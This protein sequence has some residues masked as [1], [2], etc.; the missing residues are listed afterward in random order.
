MHTCV[1]PYSSVKS[2]PAPAPIDHYSAISVQRIIASIKCCTKNMPLALKAKQ[3]GYDRLAIPNASGR[4]WEF[5]QFQVTDMQEC[6]DES[7]I[8]AKGGPSAAIASQIQL[9]RRSFPALT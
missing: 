7:A 6:T 8:H 1:R 5:C 2:W 4:E 9:H 3:E